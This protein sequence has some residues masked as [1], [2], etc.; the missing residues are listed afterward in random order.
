MIHGVPVSRARIPREL[1]NV[2]CTRRDGSGRHVFYTIY[3]LQEFKT[4]ILSASSTAA[5]LQQTAQSDSRSVRRR[6]S[7]WLPNDFPASSAGGSL[8]LMDPLAD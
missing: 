3:T 5:S 6:L 4:V 8:R 1:K 2:W 7:S